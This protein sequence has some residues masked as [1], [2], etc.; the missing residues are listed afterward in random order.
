M[1]ARNPMLSDLVERARAHKMTPSERRTQRV[2]LI[3]G[4]KD[5]TSSLTREKIEEL[6]DAHEGH[7]TVTDDKR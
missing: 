6:L 2:S 4:L 7:V 5:K 3:M 1:L